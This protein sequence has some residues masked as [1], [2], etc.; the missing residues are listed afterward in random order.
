MGNAGEAYY[1]TANITLY[2]QYVEE[3]APGISI[4]S[5]NPSTIRGKAITLTAT[6]TGSPVPTVKWYSCEDAE[7]K[8]PTAIYGATN[9]TYSPSTDTEG[10]FYY[11]AVASN[12]VNP[13]ATSDIITLTVTSPDKDIVGNAYYVATDEGAVNGEKVYCDDITME[14]ISSGAFNK[15][16]EDE[17]IK[18]LNSNYVASIASSTNGWGAEF[19]PSTTG[20]LAV[21]LVANKDKT[22]SITN[23]SSFSYKDNGNHEGTINS[24]SWDITEKFYGII[25]IN[26]VA[27]TTYKFSVA[28]SKMGLY[29][30]EFTPT[31]VAIT[32]ANAKSTYVTTKALDFSEVEGLKAYVATEATADGVTINPVGAV[33]A[34][35]PLILIGTA[36]TNYSV[37]VVASATAPTTN[38]LMAGDGTTEFNGT[39]YDY[40]LYSDGKFY[41][42]GSGTVAVGKAYLHLDSAP[43][44][45]SLQLL[46]NEEITGISSMNSE[47]ITDNRVFDLQGRTV[48][49]PKK[50]LY[51]VN[52]KKV[53]IK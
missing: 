28:G 5:Y 30:F 19:T 45:R 18:S 27:G 10:T 38:L 1:P 13:D 17:M 51:I 6:I 9:T 43:A 37:P 29:G 26:V 48:K 2:A 42:I 8:N 23:V 39:T 14:Y 33:P 11:Y 22:F 16:V 4:D 31:A 53:I 46:V 52:G 32:P 20:I 15:A 35:T 3:I 44:A 49:L 41:Q 12:G 24:N 21:G 50:G 36:G 47:G 40:I 7:K 25:T 34:E